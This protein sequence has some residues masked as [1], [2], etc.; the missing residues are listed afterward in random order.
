MDKEARRDVKE[1]V[2]RIAEQHADCLRPDLREIDEGIK[3]LR[4]R[5]QKLSLRLEG[6]T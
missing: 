3:R 2:R 6:R 5:M 1:I 4:V